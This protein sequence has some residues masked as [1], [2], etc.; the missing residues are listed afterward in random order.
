MLFEALVLALCQK[1]TF[2]GVV[3]LVNL[4]VHRVMAICSRYVELALAQANFS[5]V[6]DLAI[7]ET[8]RA[9]GHNYLSLAADVD[10]RAHGGDAE[11]IESVSTDNVARRNPGGDRAPA[12]C[13]NH[14]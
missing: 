5:E 14:L 11:A 3:K 6:K 12:E 1:M 2:I 9:R 13:A 8:S 10:L 7:D 4:S